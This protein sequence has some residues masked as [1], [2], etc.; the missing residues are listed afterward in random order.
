[1]MILIMMT[2]NNDNEYDGAAYV[3]DVTADDE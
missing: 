2:T 1:M 3:D